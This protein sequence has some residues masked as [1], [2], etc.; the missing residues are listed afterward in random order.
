L[1]AV[2]AAAGKIDGAP[3]FF[4]ATHADDA[5]YFAT[6]RGAGTILEYRFSGS[7]GLSVTPLGPQGKFGR[8]L[9]GEAVVPTGS[10]GKFNELRQAGEIVVVP[11]R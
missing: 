9:G 3:G 10:F 5:A 2:K 4:L 7:V 1:D 11:G 6:R 8:F